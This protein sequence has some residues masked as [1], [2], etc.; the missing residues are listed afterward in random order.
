V[1]ALEDG[2]TVGF[3]MSWD[4]DTRD[5]TTGQLPS[6]SAAIQLPTNPEHLPYQCMGQSS[7]KV[8]I[9]QWKAALE[10]EG[11]ENLGA[12]VQAGSGVRN[13]LSN[14]IC[15]AVDTQSTMEPRVSSFHDGR[16]WHVV[17]SR[18]L[19]P[20]DLTTAPLVTTANTAIAFAIWNGSQR[21]ARGMKAVSTWNTLEFDAPDASNVG[22]LITL[23]LVIVASAG[24]V[25]YTS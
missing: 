2:L 15:K 19:G 10:R 22:N 9:W 16:Q 13:L 21:E 25:A 6:D 14:G 4:D 20:G 24:V 18:A 5:D 23:G 8:T 11:A 7:N 12:S 1:R 17:F 3:R